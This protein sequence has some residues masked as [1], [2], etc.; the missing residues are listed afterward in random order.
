M[1][2]R[3]IVSREISFVSQ[4]ITNRV[5]VHM[6]KVQRIQEEFREVESRDRSIVEHNY[7]RVNFWSAVNLI[8]VMIVGF[9]QV[10][11]TGCAIQT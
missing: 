3:T 8:V 7:E 10:C 1:P 2:V 5:R 9:L 6:K 11:N 4:A